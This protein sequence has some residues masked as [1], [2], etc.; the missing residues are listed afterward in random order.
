MPAVPFLAVIAV[1]T[2]AAAAIGTALASAVGVASVSTVAATAIGLGTISAATTAV[3]GGSASDILK[4]A[5]LGGLTSYVGGTIAANI[6]QSVATDAFFSA[7]DA[8]FTSLATPLYNVVSSGVQGAITSSFNALINERDPIDA[9]IKGGL[10]AGLTAGVSTAV[11]EVVSQIPGIESIRSTYGGSALERALTTAVAGAAVS[12]KDFNTTLLTSLAAT[13]TSTLFGQIKSELK[14]FSSSLK[15]DS[16]VLKRSE[17]QVDGLINREKDL[18]TQINDFNANTYEPLRQELIQLS[19]NEK[20][21]VDLINGT[22]VPQAQALEAKANNVNAMVS[23]VQDPTHGVNHPYY[24]K[25][26]NMWFYNRSG[27]TIGDFTFVGER[28]GRGIRAYAIYL[29]TGETINDVNAVINKVNADVNYVNTAS[30]EITNNINAAK[31]NLAN[32]Q[33]EYGS[34]NEQFQNAQNTINQV[35]NT[36]NETRN[37]LNT[38]VNTFKANYDTYQ[39]S[40]QT[41]TSAEAENAAIVD[42]TLNDLQQTQQVWNSYFGS[43]ADDA[44]LAKLY[45]QGGNDLARGLTKAQTAYELIKSQGV[46]PEKSDVISAV[47]NNQTPESIAS[48]YV[49]FAEAR[50]FLSEL[51]YN[52]SDQEVNNFVGK[53]NEDAVKS[54]VASY[55]N[56]R[57]VT[58]AEAESY[59]RSQGYAPTDAEIKQFVGQINEST[60]QTN[61][62]SYVNPRQVTESEAKQFLQSTGYN[63]TD[64]E[65]KQF[66]GQINESTAQENIAAYVNPRQVTEAEARAFFEANGYFPTNE[67]I[68]QFVGQINEDTVQQNIRS[69]VSQEQEKT[70]QESLRK[71]QEPDNTL[72]D[73]IDAGLAVTG[74]GDPIFTAYVPVLEYYKGPNGTIYTRDLRNDTITQYLPQG[75]GTEVLGGQLILDENTKNLGTVVSGLPPGATF[76]QTVYTSDITAGSTVGASLPKSG[77]EYLITEAVDNRVNRPAYLTT[78]DL[79]DGTKQ[80]INNITGDRVIL[81]ADGNVAQ[82]FLG[83]YSK[84]NN[85]VNS[86]T[87][88]AQVGIGEL[89][90]NYAGAVQQAALKFDIDAPGVQKLIDFFQDVETRGGVM[91]PEFVNQSREKFIQDAYKDIQAAADKSETGQPSMADQYEAIKNAIKNNPVGALTLFGEEIVQNPELLLTGPGKLVGS[92]ILNVAESSGAQ[93]LQKANELKQADI[94]AGNTLKTDKEYAK[95]AASDAG[96]AAVVTGAISMIPGLGGPVAKTIKEM[97][98]EYLEEFTIAKMTGKSDA[99]AATNGAVGAFLGG[100]VAAT[101]ELGNSV[102]Q[103]TAGKIGVQPVPEVAIGASKVPGASIEVVGKTPKLPDGINIEPPSIPTGIITEPPA[104]VIGE[105]VDN[106]GT[107]IAPKEKT[108]GLTFKEIPLADGSTSPV[109]DYN[110]RKIVLVDVDGAQVPFYLSTGLAGK[111]GVPSGQWYP[112]FGISQ[113]YDANGNPTSS[114]WINKGSEQEMAS[115][116]G[117]PTLA[118]IGKKLDESIGDIRFQDTLD[119]KPIP[120]ISGQALDSPSISAIND[121]LTPARVVNT[122]QGMVVISSDAG[123]LDNSINAV[124]QIVMPTDNQKFVVDGAIQR[125][126]DGQ[127]TT[128]E[129]LNDVLQQFVDNGTLKL[130][131]LPAVIGAINQA[132]NIFAAVPPATGIVSTLPKEPTIPTT[133]PE[134]PVDTG[135]ISTIPSD[136]IIAQPVVTEPVVTEPVVTEPV[137]QQPTETQPEVITKPDVQPEVVTQPEAQQPQQETIQTTPP[138]TTTPPTTTPPIPISPPINVEPPDITKQPPGATESTPAINPGEFVFTPFEQNVIRSIFGFPELPVT[139]PLSTTTT[140]K[141]TTIKPS[142]PSAPFFP[143]LPVSEQK[144]TE[145]IDYGYPDVPPPEIGGFF[146]IP[147]PEYTQSYGPIADV[148]IMSGATK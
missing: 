102:Q 116:Y 93:A 76:Y 91:R 97:T 26:P 103:Y 46:T 125:I 4:S 21:Y 72:S 135:I 49:T 115:Y 3:Q 123:N 137:I 80:V 48:Q 105:I 24:Q 138:V 144:S 145:Y 131:Q 11:K 17:E 88:T 78:T 51:G 121:G 112:F 63:P 31:N 136:Q 59:L 56:P 62:A 129:K 98:S 117:S 143:L 12:G 32:V 128:P 64:E 132:T 7:I 130:D 66:T 79:P 89:G 54:N 84:L 73:V 74:N 58:Y 1:E 41:F 28:Y 29:P 107:L 120:S 147:P 142:V 55:V 5:V 50:Q 111:E 99:E 10:T 19:N 75:Q 34:T 22:Y 30:Q 85:F 47:V 139:T 134:T 67:E 8:G 83:K 45:E 18:V 82:E 90:K 127:I 37:N 25:N 119:G 70:R 148:G 109:V 16:D 39:T 96:I 33:A 15:N 13:G 108:S 27:T 68:K 52:P 141:P 146:Y 140:T 38:A 86:L 77:E 118:D 14:D 69:F 100:K 42:K 122:P 57:Q 2:G 71:E 124:R 60:A 53:V 133:L 23:A 114:T 106:T 20:Y 40:L 92:F 44:T 9:L 113:Q 65:V 104:D 61:I 94:K 95:L 110:Q 101:S 6:G 36:L 81:D 87:G 43:S 35:I 126:Q